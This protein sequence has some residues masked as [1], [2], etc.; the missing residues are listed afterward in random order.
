MWITI[1]FFVYLVIL[2]I[3]D[4]VNRTVPVFWLLLGSVMAVAA[5]IYNYINGVLSGGEL[6]LGM[7][8]GMLLLLVAWLSR[9]AGIADGIVLVQLGVCFGC[10]KVLVLFGWSMFLLSLV[11]IV[12][13]IAKRVKKESKMPYLTY[14][15]ITF[16]LWLPGGG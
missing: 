4:A 11:S 5:G 1:G 15:C 2:G 3:T 12:L 6:W 16:I 8:P 7:L 14:L 9:K 10:D 13:L